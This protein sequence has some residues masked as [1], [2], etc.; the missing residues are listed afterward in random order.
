MIAAIERRSNL[1]Y[2]EF[3]EEYMYANKPSVVTDATNRW[4]ALSRW[5]PE[6]FKETFGDMR[7]TISN[8]EEGQPRHNGDIDAE[9]TMARFIDRVLE[10]TDEDPAPYFRNR[11]LYDLFPA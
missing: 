5:T 11:I 7:F 2:G 6:F 10:S 3:A 1:S 9:Y 4:K 8:F